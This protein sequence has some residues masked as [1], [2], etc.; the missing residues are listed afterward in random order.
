MIKQ[1]IKQ[2]NLVSWV[3]TKIFMSSLAPKRA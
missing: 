1:W 2:Y 3:S